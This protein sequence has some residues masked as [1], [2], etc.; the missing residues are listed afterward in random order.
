VRPHFDRAAF[1]LFLALIIWAPIPLGS[2]RPWAWAI[3][4]A[5]IFGAGL[6][7]LAGCARRETVP[8]TTVRA[9]WPAFTLLGLWLLFLLLQWV[10]LPPGLVRALS[11]QAAELHA[12][13][14][15]ILGERSITLSVDP[16]ASFV[17]WLKNCAFALAF[18]LTLLLVHGRA[19]LA[20]LCGAI[21]ISGLLQAF[22]G[23]FMHL[24]RIDFEVV[25][26]PIQHTAQ[27]SGSYVNRNHLAGLLEMSLAVGIG[28]MVAQLEDRPRRSWHDFVQDTARLMLSGKAILRLVLVIMVVALV[29]TRSRMGNTAFFASLFVAGAVGLAFAR[30]ATRGTVILI[31]SLIVIDLALIGTWFGVERTLKR[32]ADTTVQNVEERVEPSV[33]AVSILDDYPLFGT[34]GGTF[35]TAF[36]RYRGHDID[37]YFDH[38]HNDYVQFLTETGIIGGALFGLLVLASFTCAIL[39]QARRR[40][41]LAR[42]LAFGVVMGITAI[43]IHSTVDFNLQIPANAFIFFILLALG[44]LSLY[45]NRAPQK[46]RNQ[47]K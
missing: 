30:H 46:P 5:G 43:G 25:G 42:G 9:A 20:W 36:T 37:A 14:D 45:L 35:Y 15:Y 7:W 1:W 10:P 27:A 11:P 29:M 6:L 22:Y 13:A 33:Y 31:A 17:F 3:L 2:N 32:I 40:D 24:A 28:M 19:R 44:W 34:G 8:G 41:P 21:V 12:A 39:A 16:H 38:V 23:S 4:E 26:V 47:E 18:A